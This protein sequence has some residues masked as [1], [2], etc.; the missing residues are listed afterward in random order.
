M[1]EHLLMIKKSVQIFLIGATTLFTLFNL[2]L[3]LSAIYE[4]SLY[5]TPLLAELAYIFTYFY[6]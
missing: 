6:L 2:L 5:R 4:S 1:K 3:V